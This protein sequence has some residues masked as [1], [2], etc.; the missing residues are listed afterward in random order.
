MSCSA[1][2]P[3]ALKRFVNIY[4]L[5]KAS[6]PDIERES[7]VEKP[8]SSPAS[9]H[10][11]CLSQLAFFT[12][13]PRLAPVLVGKLEE[14]GKKIESADPIAD[15]VSVA[16]WLDEL[17]KDAKT[18]LQS[19][20]KLIPEIDKVPLAEFRKWLPLTSRYVFHRRD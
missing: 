10:K 6:L 19:T 15:S 13:H 17:D 14:G 20:L 2:R 18:Q 9:P 16:T 1:D 8:P 12:S 4:R 11:I 5:L 3:R 7:F